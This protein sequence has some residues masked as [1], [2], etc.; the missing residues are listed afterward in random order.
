MKK[1]I[2]K[3]I[4]FLSIVLFSILL[5][6]L[7]LVAAQNEP[8]TT[9]T[10]GQNNLD[11]VITWVSEQISNSTW[12]FD[13]AKATPWFLGVLLWI[14]LYSVLIKTGIFA[15]G[16]GEVGIGAAIVSLIITILAFMYTPT[17]FWTSVAIQYSV[18]GASI[19]TLI[20]F[21]IMFYFTVAVS[22][23]LLMSYLFWIVYII[24]Y[25][26]AFIYKIASS[27]QPVFST[28]NLPYV[29]AIIAGIGILIFLGVLR[30]WFWKEELLSKRESGVRK[31]QK[32][33]AGADI[34]GSVTDTFSKK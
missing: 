27:T 14:V 3:K 8:A 28:E 24:Y 34:L 15:R 11:K 13:A 31:V 19:L 12:G 25:F 29:I 17:E 32:A 21:L 9:A 16:T 7:V 30:K 6:N 18:L 33:K 23:S 10:T 1:E 5:I 20:P 4:L 26:L 22:E 2:N